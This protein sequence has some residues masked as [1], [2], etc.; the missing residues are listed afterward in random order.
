VTTAHDLALITKAA[1]QTAEF[2][3]SVAKK[4]YPWSYF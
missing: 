4:D 3:R 1:L 2:R